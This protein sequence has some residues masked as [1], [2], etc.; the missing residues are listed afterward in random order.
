MK[1]QK[2]KK[3]QKK[4]RCGSCKTVLIVEEKDVQSR[5]KFDRNSEDGG[6]AY[7]VTCTRCGHEVI[8]EQTTFDPQEKDPVP[9]HVKEE[10]NKRER[11]KLTVKKS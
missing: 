1:I 6:V 2:S 4:T 8:L 3:W 11:K 5:G 9:P 10:A 7:F